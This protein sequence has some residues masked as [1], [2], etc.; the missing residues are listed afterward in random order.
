M[1]NLMITTACNFRCPYCFGMDLFGAGRSRQYMPVPLFE[2]L[3]AWIDRANLPNLSIHLMGGE[4][5]LHPAFSHMA[6]E[7]ARRG[8]RVAVFSNAAAPLDAAVVRRS[9]DAGVRWIINCN[10]PDTYRDNQLDLLHQH[11]AFLGRA[12]NITFNLTN[13]QTPFQYVLDYIEQYDLN[14]SIK[15]GVALPTL[16]HRNVHAG[17]DA[18]PAIAQQILKLLSETRRRGISLEFEC[19]VPFCLFSEKEHAELGD[20]HVS[21]CASRLDITPTGEVIN[22]LPLCRVASVPFG[23]FQNYHEAREWFQRMQAPYRQVGSADRCLSCTYRLQGRCSACL[24]QGMGEYSRIALP[25]LPD[26]EP[27]ESS[28]PGLSSAH[29]IAS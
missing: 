20:I 5:T 15:L 12:G 11:L 21:H 28:R 29:P 14:R 27:A 13:G 18:L 25:P 9:V 17:W 26:E 16:E 3:L 24:A 1:A 10:P 7:L 8:R 19:G 22:C 23:R 4:P 6:D 2:E